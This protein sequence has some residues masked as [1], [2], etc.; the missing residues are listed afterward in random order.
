LTNEMVVSD[1]YCKQTEELI[2]EQ[3]D[4]IKRLEDQL[5]EAE[6]HLVF[7]EER[8]EAVVRVYIIHD[9]FPISHDSRG[10]YSAVVPFN[11][12]QTYEILIQA[13]LKDFEGDYQDIDDFDTTV[14]TVVRY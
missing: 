1:Y 13:E 4:Y 5:I 12:Y 9:G 7:L 10:V 2:F 6:N 3:K 8:D 11:S 14:E